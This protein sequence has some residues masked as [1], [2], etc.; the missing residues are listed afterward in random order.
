[1]EH[2]FRDEEGNVH[3]D[4]YFEYLKSVEKHFPP[5]VY[6]FAADFKYYSLHDHSSLHDA[7]LDYL[8]IVE[9]AEGERKEL[10]KIEIDTC[11]LGRFH[12]RRIF[13]SYKNV[14]RYSLNT[15]SDVAALPANQVG[16]GDLLIHELRIHPSGNIIHEM[17]F[18]RGSILLI[19]CSDLIHR[20]ELFPLGSPDN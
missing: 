8:H 4:L 12:D 15:P 11:F 17:E 3:F 6:S 9:S 5:H 13:F 7:W 18:S 14:T 19:R 2:I 16:H 10:S 20:E 1:M